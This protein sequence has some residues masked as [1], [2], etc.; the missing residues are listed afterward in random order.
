MKF[1]WKLFIWT[2]ASVTLAYCLSGSM[3]ITSAF[4]VTYD[5]EVEI[6]TE[7]HEIMQNTLIM[8]LSHLSK[9]VTDDVWRQVVKDLD[10][11]SARKNF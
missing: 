10:D 8:V 5:K 7:E 3:M 11:T 4:R 2:M 9:N 6:A 1:K